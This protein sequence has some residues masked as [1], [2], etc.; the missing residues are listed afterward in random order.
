[1]SIYGDQRFTL[2]GDVG[3]EDTVV[4]DLTDLT[5]TADGELGDNTRI[6]EITGGQTN[7]VLD[8]LTFTGGR[9]FSYGGAID[10]FTSGLTVRNATFAGNVDENGFGSGAIY[11]NAQLSVENSTFFGNITINGDK[12][13]GHGGGAI[14]SSCGDLS[15]RNSTFVGQRS[16]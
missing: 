16:D 9:G 1:M 14:F 3:N 15:V 12:V 7:V 13:T 4:N 2:S 11:S 8:G 5:N 10:A 6:V